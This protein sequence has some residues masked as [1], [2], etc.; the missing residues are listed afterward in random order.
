M[1]LRL[2][3][4]RTTLNTLSSRAQSLMLCYVPVVARLLKCYASCTSW[5]QYI[6]CLVDV[7]NFS[8][9]CIV[10]HSV[11]LSRS[12]SMIVGSFLV[13]TDRCS[14]HCRSLYVATTSNDS[15][16]KTRCHFDSSADF[17]FCPF[18]DL[19]IVRPR[20]SIGLEPP[21]VL[22]DY[23]KAAMTANRQAQKLE[24]TSRGLFGVGTYSTLQPC[25]ASQYAN[26]NR[27]LHVRP[28]AMA[29]CCRLAR[30]AVNGTKNY[31]Q[32]SLRKRPLCSG[33]RNRTSMY[34]RRGVL[35]SSRPQLGTSDLDNLL[36]PDLHAAR[37]W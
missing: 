27:L 7:S 31:V 12:L 36:H 34:E 11:Q 5:F 32:I 26:A 28:D 19:D 13:A 37:L 29:L 24:H 23:R 35:G 2:A 21:E 15:S 33:L 10:N 6:V 17:V 14:G 9:T 18:S 3:C 30:R 20:S 22:P 25:K 16:R 8:A 4:A 1:L